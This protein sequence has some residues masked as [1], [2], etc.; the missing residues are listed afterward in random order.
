MATIPCPGCRTD[1][2][3]EVTVCPICLRPRG[4]LEITRAYATLR[5]LEKQRRRRPFVIAGYMLAAGAASWFLY[6][7]HEPIASA[8]VSAR[9]RV[10]RFA[11]EALASADPTANRPGALPAEAA[12]TESAPSPPG[13]PASRNASP[14]DVIVF[15]PARLPP[16]KTA[17]RPGLV[18]DLPLPRFDAGSQWVFYGR[19]Y[20]LITLLPVPDVQLSFSS[21]ASGA[22][23][24]ARSDADGRFAVVLPRLSQGSYEIRGA[25]SGYASP[26]LYEPDIPYSRLPLAE[27]R[28]IALN[29]QDGDMPLPPLTDVAGEASVRRD[30]F[31]APSR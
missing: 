3:P 16:P 25:H 21:V 19:V 12:K 1:L 14:T 30:V 27:R 5:E 17:Q 4:K 22:A 26:A 7:Y 13:A 18:E 2:E 31:L 10:G 15:A 8:Y 29:A 23:N 6:T 24:G 9:A 28:E 20:D 11:D